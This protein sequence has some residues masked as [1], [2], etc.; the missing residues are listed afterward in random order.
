M[1]TDWHFISMKS[2]EMTK[3]LFLHKRVAAT[4]LWNATFGLFSLDLVTCLTLLRK[5][6]LV[7]NGGFVVLRK[8]KFCDVFREKRNDGALRIRN[9]R[10]WMLRIVFLALYN[11]F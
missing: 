3:N 5:Y 9:K 10:R 8:K 2:G 1:V 11:W 6:C 7:R 4:I